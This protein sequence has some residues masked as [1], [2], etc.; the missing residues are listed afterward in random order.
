MYYGNESIADTLAMFA[1]AKLVVAFHGAALVNIFFSSKT[2]KV[3]EIT[4][5]N[6]SKN[7]SEPYDTNTYRRSVCSAAGLRCRVVCLAPTAESGAQTH[8]LISAQ[9]DAKRIHD[10]LHATP[11][12]RLNDAA[13]AAVAFAAGRGDASNATAEMVCLPK[14]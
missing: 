8:R 1:S 12:V 13:V 7:P 4:F 14:S 3:I 11:C 10:V 2:A 6:K 5:W 9:H